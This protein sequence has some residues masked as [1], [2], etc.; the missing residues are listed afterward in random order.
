[1]QEDQKDMRIKSIKMSEKESYSLSIVLPVFNVEKYLDRCI[2]CILE[3]TY[4]DLE[5]VIV[6]DGT[7][8]NSENIIILHIE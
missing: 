2:K 1:M 8:D 6:N 7:K 4:K 5:L 3:G